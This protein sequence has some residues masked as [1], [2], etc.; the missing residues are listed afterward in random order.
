MKFTIPL[1]MEWPEITASLSFY[2]PIQ[3]KKVI[4]ELIKHLREME[5]VS[6]EDRSFYEKKLASLA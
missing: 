3:R 4:E 2:T 6:E 1:T 5:F